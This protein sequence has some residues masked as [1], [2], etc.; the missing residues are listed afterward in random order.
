[1]LY[2]QISVVMGGLPS[3]TSLVTEYVGSFIDN[4]CAST[5]NTHCHQ[6]TQQSHYQYTYHVLLVQH[7]CYEITNICCYFLCG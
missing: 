5:A 4:G 3:M 6:L 2:L 1:M 7:V